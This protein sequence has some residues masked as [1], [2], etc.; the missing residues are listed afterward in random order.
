MSSRMASAH[1]RLKAALCATIPSRYRTSLST[2]ISSGTA[3]ALDGVAVVTPPSCRRCSSG[4]PCHGPAAEEVEMEVEDALARLGSDVRHHPVA[5]A[6]TGLVRDAL[7]DAEEP[8]QQAG[9]GIGQ[10][11]GIGDVAARDDE[12]VRRRLRVDVA[13]GDDLVILVDPVG[14]DLARHDAAEEAV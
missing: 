1:S 9:V 8:D 11:M 5:A 14:R 2:A 3:D 13:E 10:G 12:H 6:E 7:D 4:R